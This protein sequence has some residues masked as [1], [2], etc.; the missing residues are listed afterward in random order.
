MNTYLNLRSLGNQSTVE[1]SILKIQLEDLGLRHTELRNKFYWIIL[2]THI[3]HVFFN[4]EENKSIKI[5]NSHTFLL[6]QILECR[7]HVLQ[8]N[9]FKVILSVSDIENLS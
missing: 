4:L 2:F 5:R 1:K 9:V 3:I 8:S 6:V 7:R